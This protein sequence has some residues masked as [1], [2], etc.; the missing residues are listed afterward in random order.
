MGVNFSFKTKTKYIYSL[1]LF[2]NINQ[3]VFLQNINE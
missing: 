3:I 2:N 1:Q